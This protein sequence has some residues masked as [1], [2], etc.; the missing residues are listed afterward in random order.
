M[1]M[2][3]PVCA[4]TDCSF[5]YFPSY[6]RNTV[7]GSFGLIKILDVSARRC[8]AWGYVQL[9]VAE[10]VVLKKKGMLIETKMRSRQDC[11][12]WKVTH[13]PSATT[14]TLNLIG[15]THPVSGEHM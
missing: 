7:V 14:S 8:P 2:F 15:D 11:P 9:V 13:F 4:K 12:S 3:I 1:G 5:T 10:R 6:T